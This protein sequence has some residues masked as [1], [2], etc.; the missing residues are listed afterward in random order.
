MMEGVAVVE[1]A[2]DA[3]DDSY[4]FENTGYVSGNALPLT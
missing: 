1:D 2:A 3:V 4:E